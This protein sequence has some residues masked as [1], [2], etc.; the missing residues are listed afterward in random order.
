LGKYATGVLISNEGPFSSGTGTLSWYDKTK[1]LV[2]NDVFQTANGY[3]IG[4][5]F[6]SVWSSASVNRAYLVVNNSQKVIAV[7]LDN[8]TVLKEIT[9]F[10]SPRYFQPVGGNK[11]YVTDWVSNTVKI[12]DMTT[13]TIIG[14]KP[15]GNGPERILV[16][17][18]RALVANSGGFGIDS[19]ITVLNT[20]SD[21]VQNTFVVGH[22][23]NSM[24]IDANGL[25]WVL[26]GGINDWAT[27]TNNTA[28]KLIQIDLGTF[29]VIN[30]F[31]FPTNSNHPTALAKNSAGTLL[32]WLDNNYAGNVF[33]MNISASTLPVTPKI[34]GSFYA[35]AIDPSTDEIYVSD[36]KDFQQDG[37][38]S[39]YSNS[40]QLIDSETV[41]VIPG[42]FS[43]N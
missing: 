29:T 39:R 22:N 30:E 23:P 42:G 34:S 10:S 25:L 11:A 2:E 20:L 1:K 4:S 6:H 28:G 31:T 7:K 12:V 26:C 36:A 24:V 37:V 27:P 32:Y 17:G 13:N 5:V 38:V 35:L 14:S 9:G 41:G 16:Y 8:L 3:P 18:T 40:G 15:A 19:T 33:E 43:F 21:D